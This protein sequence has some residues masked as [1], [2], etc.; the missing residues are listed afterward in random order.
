MI[1]LIHDIGILQFLCGPIR[2]VSAISSNARRGFAVEDTVAMLFVFE[3]GALGIFIL[4]DIA[5][6]DRSWELSSGENPAYPHSKDASCYHFAGTNGSLDF[7][8]LQT[9]FYDIDVTPSWWNAFRTETLDA[10]RIEPLAK[11]LAHFED[12]IAGTAAPV[13]SAKVGL[14]NMRVLE[15]VKRATSS[16]TM[17]DLRSITP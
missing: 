8:T 11:Q 15:A 10:E 13:V 3:N 5:A 16:G 9:R 17:V 2:S 4:S 1:N 7:P 14:E 6:S 12:V